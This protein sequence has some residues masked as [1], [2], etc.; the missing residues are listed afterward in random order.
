MNLN[1]WADNFKQ[2]GFFIKG[3]KPGKATADHIGFRLNRISFIGALSL[4]VIAI[5][6]TMIGQAFG[7]DQ[8][9]SYS[10]LGGVGLLI[11][12]G[13]GLDIIQKVSSFLLSHQYQ[14]LM[15]TKLVAPVVVVIPSQP[16]L[17]R[18]APSAS[19]C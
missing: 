7:L 14:G 6:P 16:S 2:G 12:V 3:V 15:Q 17:A 11:V 8:N 18:V 1:E 13:V 10:L 5:V 9:A 4:A 19:N